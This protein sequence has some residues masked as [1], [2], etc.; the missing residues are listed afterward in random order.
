M[1]SGGNSILRCEACGKL[2]RIRLT[3]IGGRF[4]ALAC[5]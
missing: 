5:F 4:G 2:L 3:V 1:R